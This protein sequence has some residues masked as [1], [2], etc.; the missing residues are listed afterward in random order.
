MSNFVSNYNQFLATMQIKQNYISRKSGIDENKLSRILTG[1]QSASEE[2][3]EVLS[4]AVGKT[5]FYFLNPN[6]KINADYSVSSARIAFYAGSPTKKQSRVA[7]NLL[8]LMQNVDVVMSAK[9]LFLNMGI[10]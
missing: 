2:D 1:K 6:F 10:E 3:L 8:E 4:K 5:M 7:N 9:G